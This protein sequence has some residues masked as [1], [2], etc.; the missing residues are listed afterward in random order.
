MQYID[1]AITKIM[2][3]YDEDRTKARIRR[4][5]MV[6]SVYERVPEVKKKEDEITR[7]GVENLGKILKNPENAAEYNKEF[8]HKLAALNEEKNKILLENKIPLDYNEVKYK[9]EK[10]LDTGYEDKKKCSCFLQ[11]LIKMRYRLSNMGDMLHDFSEFSFDYYSDKYIDSLKMTERENMQ[12]IFKRAQSFCRDKKGKN[13]LFYGDCGLGKTFLSSCIA[14]KMMDNGYS[15]LYITAAGLF[16]DY[17]DYRF[18][19]KENLAFSDTMEMLYESD[20]VIIDDLGTEAQNSFSLQFFFDIVGKRLA[21][22]KKIILNTNLNMSEISARY[23]NRLTSRIY[24]SFEIL[25]FV[26][27]DIR[28]QKLMKGNK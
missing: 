8:E 6:K 18:G 7:L 5:R 19:R 13:L 14:K 20:L 22:K 4:D 12:D 3:E 11:K 9:C 16:T 17:E 24:E 28:I 2:N 21:A 15:V 27:K 25:Q 23:S 10:C 1:D 26:G